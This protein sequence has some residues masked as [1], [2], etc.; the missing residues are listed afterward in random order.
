LRIDIQVTATYRSTNLTID[1]QV[2]NLSQTGLFL[3]CNQVDVLGTEGH[4]ELDR[5]GDTTLVVPGTVVW[6]N[7]V[8][9]MGVRFAE[10]SRDLR[11]E[12]ANFIIERVYR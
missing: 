9:G 10:L 1:A 3:A 5:P 7:A 6:S 8:V 12:L 11:L 4:V 2:K